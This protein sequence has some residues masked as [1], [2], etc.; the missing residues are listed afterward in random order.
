MLQ[1]SFPQRKYKQTLFEILSWFEIGHV[2]VAGEWYLNKLH[3]MMAA[4]YNTNIERCDVRG[5]NL[6]CLGTRTTRFVLNFIDYLFYQESLSKEKASKYDFDFRYYNSVEHHLPQSSESYTKYGR[7]IIDN[8]GNLYL[9]SKRVNSSLNDNDPLSKTNK[10]LATHPRLAPK[11]ALMYSYTKRNRQWNKDDILKHE[12]E[13]INLL[14]RRNEILHLNELEDSN[15]SLRAIL[16]TG[17][18]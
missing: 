15:L 7:E 5:E 4:L 13:I 10:V 14:D 17:C 16:A 2:D 9:I 1:V 3:R 18:S 11:R 6:L 12:G 8:I